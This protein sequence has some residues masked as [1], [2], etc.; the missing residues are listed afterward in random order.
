MFCPKCGSQLP[1]AAMFCNK[2]GSQ[3][4]ARQQGSP[5]AAP[6]PA[7]P[8][9][10]APGASPF[11]NQPEAN[12]FAA[13]APAPAAAASR[14]AAG[15]LAG[16]MSG[17]GIGARVAAVVTVIFMLMPWLSVPFLRSAGSLLSNFGISTGT[18]PD[19]TMYGMGD[20]TQTLDSLSSSNAFG[21]VHTLFLVVW[22][23]ALLAL[24]AGLI[25]SFTS[26]S[27]SARP[28]TA[29]GILAGVVAILWFVAISAINGELASQ[30]SSYFGA[31][32]QVFE[33]PFAVIMTA[34]C[35]LA[36]GVLAIMDKQ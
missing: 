12:P 6:R 36:T 30:M 33:V 8:R 2:C 19:Y 3:L 18:G 10:A 34:I 26:T 25:I 22:G 11:A 20:V 24:V 31:G 29:G 14:S 5:Q 7:A 35:G 1:D 27:K 15:D 4:A 9:Q 16:S 21:M 32:T 23:V 13:P 17:I 28:L